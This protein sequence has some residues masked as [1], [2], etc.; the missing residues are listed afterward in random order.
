[1]GIYSQRKYL[2]LHILHSVTDF[3]LNKVPPELTE[4]FHKMIKNTTE[5]LLLKLA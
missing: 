5:Q 2:L 1:M 4:K 3:I